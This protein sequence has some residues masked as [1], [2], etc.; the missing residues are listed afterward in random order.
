MGIHLQ[1]SLT[2]Q[3]MEALILA[4]CLSRIVCIS[5]TICVID[6]CSNSS[7]H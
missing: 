2:G 5:N 3:C 1:D 6:Q 7:Q 4:A